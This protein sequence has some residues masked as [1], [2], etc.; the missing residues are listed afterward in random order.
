MNYTPHIT[1]PVL[2]IGGR[3]DYVFPVETAQRPLFEQLGTP[4][5]QKRHLLYEMGHGPIPRGQFLRDVLPW[6]DQVL[7][8]VR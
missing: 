8:P 1:M 5:G 7:G 3:D 6:L 2:M 4:P